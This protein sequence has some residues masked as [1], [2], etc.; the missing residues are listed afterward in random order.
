MFEDNYFIDVGKDKDT[1]KLIIKNNSGKVVSVF[2]DTYAML[3][4]VSRQVSHLIESSYMM[5]YG[6]ARSY[7]DGDL[8]FD[9]FKKYLF[10]IFL[11]QYASYL[12]N[13]NGY[14]IKY[15]DFTY[16]IATLY[17]IYKAFI[18]PRSTL[19]LQEF[20][21]IIAPLLT[22]ANPNLTGRELINLFDTFAINYY[23]AIDYIYKE[24]LGLNNINFMSAAKRPMNVE[25]NTV[26]TSTRP[27]SPLQR[28]IRP[29]IHIQS[30][31][32][33]QSK[34]KVLEEKKPIGPPTLEEEPFDKNLENK[35]G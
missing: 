20:A 2:N 7:K 11:E 21:L 1:F 10:V 9:L 22:R 24:R 12:A 17:K 34:P 16:Y 27:I 23:R 35:N 14:R 15:P 30:T 3:N 13:L 33:L 18:N 5:I 4:Q 26:V 25:P 6:R 28:I 29:Q 32:V 31:S 8:I 19:S